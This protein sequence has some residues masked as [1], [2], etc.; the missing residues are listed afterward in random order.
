[1]RV[2]DALEA[3][4]LVVEATLR[5]L[6]ANALEQPLELDAAQRS[7]P[8]GLLAT[9]VAQIEIG[10]GAG[11]HQMPADGEPKNAAHV[12]QQ[13]IRRRRRF[14]SHAGEQTR[15]HGRRDLGGHGIAELR[16]HVFVEVSA[17][18]G[19]VLEASA[20][21]FGL[22]PV[23]GQLL[24]FAAR[25][26]GGAGFEL[27]VDLVLLLQKRVAACV[28]QRAFGARGLAGVRQL[29]V[30]VA[31]E[32]HPTITAAETVAQRPPCA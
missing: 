5:H 12:A 11:R 27:C 3:G 1:M 23:L 6:A 4:Q 31:A 10:Y 22:V 20:F 21:D 25:L 17:R 29:H 9:G 2:V 18:D 8:R 7:L 16:K 24:E 28:D 15:R 32:R 26:L 30:W 13:I 19:R 14:L